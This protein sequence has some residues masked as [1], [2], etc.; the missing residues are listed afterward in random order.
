MD[1]IDVD[2]FEEFQTQLL[3]RAHV[4]GG[5]LEVWHRL[6]GVVRW[7][8]ALVAR[9]NATES[10]DRSG[11]VDRTPSR[12]GTARG[13]PTT[14]HMA[15]DNTW[16]LYGDVWMPS[17]NMME[18]VYLV[19]IQ[20]VHARQNVLH[21]RPSWSPAKNHTLHRPTHDLYVQTLKNVRTCPGYKRSKQKGA[22]HPRD[23]FI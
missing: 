13:T 9:T 21:H 16:L 8:T 17:R 3:E 10:S 12:H 14:Q 11:L 7:Q 20:V 2:A 15:G 22:K 5:H 18:Y 4:D 6:Q 23:I 19:G 1:G